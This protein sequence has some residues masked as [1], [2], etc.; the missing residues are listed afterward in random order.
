MLFLTRYITHLCAIGFFFLMGMGMTFFANS[1]I[2]SGWTPGLHSR[3][4]LLPV[5]GKLFRFFLVRGIV[6]FILQFVMEDV[7]WNLSQFVPKEPSPKIL[8]VFF[9]I[10][11]VSFCLSYREIGFRSYYDNVWNSPGYR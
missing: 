1:R 3:K 4:F 5:K 6:L 8:F 7:V 11:Q 2:N 10:L 9:G